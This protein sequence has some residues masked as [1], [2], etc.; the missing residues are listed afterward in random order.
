MIDG[1]EFRHAEVRSKTTVYREKRAFTLI[2]VKLD[3]AR[4]IAAR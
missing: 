4:R 3:E 1:F 2:K